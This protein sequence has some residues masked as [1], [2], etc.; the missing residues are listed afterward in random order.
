MLPALV[1]IQLG[2]R[3]PKHLA[4]N[5]SRSKTLFPEIEVVLAG[6]SSLAR[7]NAERYGARY[8]ELSQH[9]G[10]P[11]LASDKIRRSGFDLNFWGG[12]WQK[13]LDRLIAFDVI[14][15]QLGL[16]P[17]L[18]IEGDVIL[19]P[20]FPFEEIG[21]S[22]KLRWVGHT[23]IADIASIVLSPS[24]SHSKWF[25]HSLTEIVSRDPGLT[26]MLA[27]CELRR[28]F[29]DHVALLPALPS[30]SNEHQWIFDGLQFGDWMFGQDP[31]AHW[32]FLRRRM[33]TTMYSSELQDHNLLVQE[34][35][36]IL[37][38]ATGSARIANLHVHSKELRFFKTDIADD[39]T[40]LIK[41]ISRNRL[42][43]GFNPKAA[44][45]WA[46]SRIR[47]WSSSLF[48]PEAW[49]NLLTSTSKS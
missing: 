24:P 35:E 19:M 42:F 9:F 11:K 46:H 17:M 7:E 13:T 25:S 27:L 14:H 40:W 21:R 18:H 3:V 32:G 43:Y 10:N 23:E 22:Q 38:G 28:A 48:R 26:D 8:I 4:L 45:A 6:N 33:K 5:L 37:E 16:K 31:N 20:N 49:K 29:S 34:G 44:R 41:Q 2:G 36:L 47:R 30:K 1:F 15:G 39:L 12:Y